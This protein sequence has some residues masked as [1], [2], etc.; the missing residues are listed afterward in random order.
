MR[1]KAV[2]PI[3]LPVDLFCGEGCGRHAKRGFERVTEVRLFSICSHNKVLSV[4]PAY[5][6]LSFRAVNSSWVRVRIDGRGKILKHPTS[7]L[8][9]RVSEGNAEAE[10]PPEDGAEGGVTDVLDEDVLGVLDRHGADLEIR[11]RGGFSFFCSTDMIECGEVESA[12]R[13]QHR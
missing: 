11:C 4:P 10:Q 2:V 8:T 1:A 7:A 9:A 5:F 3:K 6:S 12:S 13:G